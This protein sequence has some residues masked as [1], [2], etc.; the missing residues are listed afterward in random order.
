MFKVTLSHFELNEIARYSVF[1]VHVNMTTNQKKRIHIIALP[2]HVLLRSTLQ[3]LSLKSKIMVKNDVSGLSGH[4]WQ[5][6]A[7]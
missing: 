6:P 5:L 2:Y 7:N 3:K 1:L 4:N